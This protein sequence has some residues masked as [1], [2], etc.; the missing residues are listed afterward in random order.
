MAVHMVLDSSQHYKDL[1]N[2]ECYEE[3]LEMK[4]RLE[5]EMT[6]GDIGKIAIGD[7]GI[8]IVNFSLI[9]TQTGFCVAYFIFMGN[10]VKE[11]FPVHFYNSSRRLGHAFSSIP[12]ADTAVEST[13][14]NASHMASPFIGQETAP[15]FVLLLL[16]PYPFLVLMSFIR[17]VRKLGPVSGIANIAIL[18]G[19][20]G[21]LTYILKGGYIIKNAMHIISGF[22]RYSIPGEEHFR[23]S[24][25][26]LFLMR[27]SVLIIV[28]QIF[29]FPDSLRSGPYWEEGVGAGYFPD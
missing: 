13:L 27:T 12:F 11:M 10:T 15:S 8:R 22:A 28:V 25:F 14:Q 5:K 23:E 6:L 29:S 16:I 21:L 4:D 9:L 2:E 24:S 19:F 1:E 7:W 17:N 26:G 3:M 18:G 20:T